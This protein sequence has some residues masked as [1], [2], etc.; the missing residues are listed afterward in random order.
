MYAILFFR[1]FQ[2]MAFEVCFMPA[3]PSFYVR[4][5]VYKRFGLYDLQFKTSSDFEMMVR[6]FGKHNIRAKYI[7]KDFVTMR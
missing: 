4:R 7:H 5:D 2:T 6:L 3:H 1:L